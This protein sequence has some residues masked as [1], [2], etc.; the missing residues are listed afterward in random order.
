MGVGWPPGGHAIVRVAAQRE[1]HRRP[2]TVPA[3]APCMEPSLN[4]WI[5]S[6]PPRN[7]R[8]PL[9]V[10]R[11]RLPLGRQLQVDMMS[12]KEAQEVRLS[13]IESLSVDE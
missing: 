8:L 1:E 5:S 13:K 11:E 9:K 10:M 4:P 3:G 7:K 6:G 2:R 12:R